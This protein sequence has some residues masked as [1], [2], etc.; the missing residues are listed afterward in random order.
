MVALADPRRA[1]FA[2]VLTAVVMLGMAISG[3]GVCASRSQVNRGMATINVVAQS[4]AISDPTTISVT[5]QLQEGTAMIESFLYG[6]WIG[7]Q[8][9][10]WFFLRPQ[11]HLLSV[12][13]WEAL[14]FRF[15][16]K[17]VEEE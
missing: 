17:R 15:D 16:A 11:T 1:K 10:Y 14:R 8:A 7:G 6:T 2:V 3:C 13:Y 12:L 4:G 9:L 5:V